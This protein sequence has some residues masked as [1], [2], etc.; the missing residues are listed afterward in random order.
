[1][2]SFPFLARIAPLAWLAVAPFALAC[3]A[4]GDVYVESHTGASQSSLACDV[5]P[6]EDVCARSFDGII[7]P[8]NRPAV[9]AVLASVTEFAGIA[10]EAHDEIARACEA[11]VDGLGAAR[12][13]QPPGVDDKTRTK[14][15]C[16]AAVLA[17]GKVNRSSFSLAVSGAP[18]IDVPKPTCA[19]KDAPPSLYCPTASVTL[20]VSPDA[21]ARD[22][23]DGAALQKNLARIAN[24]QRRVEQ[25]ARLTGPITARADA[26]AEAGACRE[27][28][29]G[30]VTNGIAEARAS[31]EL[32]TSLMSAIAP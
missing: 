25:L 21:S 26:L 9:V 4:G 10:R 16:D 5:T 23:T 17:I 29:I 31:V 18:C 27:T 3:T 24:V 28:A 19:A 14:A 13:I 12:P 22:A 30:L 32:A 6:G 2:S 20:T 15:T 11:I 1:M 8:E 7:A